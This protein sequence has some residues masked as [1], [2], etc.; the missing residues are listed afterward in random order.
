MCT[1]D[2]IFK[3]SFYPLGIKNSTPQGVRLVNPPN[4]LCQCMKLG[5]LF[6]SPSWQTALTSLICRENGFTQVFKH[7]ESKYDIIFARSSSTG[8][9]SICKHACNL[10]YS[11]CHWQVISE[12]LVSCLGY[13]AWKA[14]LTF[15]WH[16]FLIIVTGR[17]GESPVTIIKNI[18][19]LNVRHA[20][21][22]S[23]PGNYLS[24]FHL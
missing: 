21:Q 14:W 3:F 24:R 23:Y 22:A 13:E 20:F 5:R 19:Q 17:K 4:P 15:N 11:E 7:E 2:L 12:N 10:M 8:E 9:T 6:T 1:L 16:I 18:S